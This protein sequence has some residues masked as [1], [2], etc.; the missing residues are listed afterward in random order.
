MEDHEIEA[1]LNERGAE[2]WEFCYVHRFNYFF[3][4]RME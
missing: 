1:F 4:R 2:G 3:K